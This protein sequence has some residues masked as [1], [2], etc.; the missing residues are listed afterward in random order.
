[1]MKERSSLA[2]TLSVW[3]A[4]FLRETI[5][6]ISARRAA[7]VWM[8]AEPI[9]HIAFLVLIFSLIRI[10]A[11]AGA[12]FVLF[13]A[14]GLLAFFLV[15][16]TTTRGMEAVNANSTLFAYRQVKP[17]D[18]VIVRC[19][20]EG[21][22][23]LAIVVILFSGFALFGKQVLPHD[24]LLVMTCLFGLWLLGVGLALMFSVAIGL[25]QELGNVVSMLFRPLYLISGKFFPGMAIPLPYRE[26]LFY[27]PIING[28]EL[29]RAGMFP[30]FTPAPEASLTYLYQFALVTLF[31]GLLLH[32]RFKD[33]LVMS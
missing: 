9:A 31:L 25:V 11:V 7:A 16:K 26:Y 29:L 17:I 18:T 21:L 13:L 5:S 24:P 19:A 6:R 27:N 20:L 14:S 4:L 28:L 30:Q 32:I 8:L 2:V 10:R 15:Q 33:R 3:K 1:M 12:D 22:L 23:T